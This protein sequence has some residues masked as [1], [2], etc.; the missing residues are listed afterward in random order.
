MPQ[1]GRQELSGRNLFARPPRSGEQIS[2]R[3][4]VRA[5]TRHRAGVNTPRT[6]SCKPFLVVNESERRVT[7][8]HDVSK[9]IRDKVNKAV[10]RNIRLL[11]FSQTSSTILAIDW[12]KLSITDASTIRPYPTQVNIN[13]HYE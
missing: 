1:R 4:A 7:F 8:S 3:D 12:L 11:A 10:S 6:A 9:F 5:A 13:R 2:I